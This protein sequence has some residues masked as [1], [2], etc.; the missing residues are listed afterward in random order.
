MSDDEWQLPV[1]EQDPESRGAKLVRDESGARLVPD[2]NIVE[3]EMEEDARK[4]APS[5]PFSGA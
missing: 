1:P 5:C 4:D 2:G 3:G